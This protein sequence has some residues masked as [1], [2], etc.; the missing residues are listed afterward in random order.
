M[1]LREF[2]KFVSI[3]SIIINYHLYEKYVFINLYEFLESDVYQFSQ[4]NKLEKIVERFARDEKTR[5]KASRWREEICNE[6]ASKHISEKTRKEPR[7]SEINTSAKGANYIGN[8][9]VVSPDS[10]AH[11]R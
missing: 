5:T 8:I 2:Y 3:I 10:T 6:S 9:L 7:E 11:H 1:Y 4:K